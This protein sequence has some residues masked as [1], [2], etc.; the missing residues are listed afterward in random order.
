MFEQSIKGSCTYKAARAKAEIE[1]F[2]EPSVAAVAVE[3]HASVVVKFHRVVLIVTKLYVICE[4]FYYVNYRR[5]R[6][7]KVLKC[8]Q[9]KEVHSLAQYALWRAYGGWV[10]CI[11]ISYQLTHC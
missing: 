2:V 7:I 1:G 3:K 9:P 8:G 5:R 10:H 11:I 4:R 6:V